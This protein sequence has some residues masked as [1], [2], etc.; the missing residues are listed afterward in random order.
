MTL[1]RMAASSPGRS[2]RRL[3]GGDLSFD[4]AV[5]H[6]WRRRCSPWT[7]RPF[8]TLYMLIC[9]LF[10]IF[11]SPV[12]AVFIEFD[13][14]L[15]PNIINST[16]RRLQFVPLFFDAK[17]N[18]SQ[19]SYNL[20]ITVFGNVTGQAREGVYPPPDDPSW[21]DPE[22]TVGKIIA[23]SPTNNKFSTLFSRYEVLSYTPY[24][25][26]GSQ[27]C[28]STVNQ[29]CPL[30]PAFD[31]NESDPSTLPGFTVAH[32]FYNSY[33]FSTL[34]STVYVRSGDMGAPDLACVSASIT[35]ALSNS[36][37]KALCITPAAI[38]AL[39]A[40][41]TVCAAI[42]SP[43]GTSNI[44]RWSSNYG[45]DEDLLRLVTPG[46]GDCL[47]YLQF[48]FLL[49]CLSLNYPGYFQPVVSKFS[50]TVLMF[51]ESFV[52]DGNGYE[53]LTDGI[54]RTDGD[55]GLTR[56][57]QLVGMAEDEDLWAGVMIWL[58][59]VIGAVVLLSQ[60]GFVVYWIYRFISKR[61]EQDL[62]SKNLPFTIGNVIRIVY[63]LFLLPL[64][65]FSMFQF[66]IAGESRTAVVAVAVIFLVGLLT[67]SGWILRN[68]FTTKPRS[69]LFDDLPT[70]LLYGPLYNTY[71]D[72]APPF[73]FNYILLTIFRGVAI[74]AV[75]QSGIAQLVLLA[76][77]EV[78]FILTLHAFRP[79]SPATSMN[80]YH[81][82]FAFARLAATL[83]SVAFV[84]SLGV[85][86]DS[87]GWIGYVILLLHGIVLV[88]GFFLNAI[89]TIVEVLARAAGAGGESRGPLVRAF[90]SRQLARRARR[91]DVRGSLNSEAAMFSQEGDVKS[92]PG[93]DGRSRSLSAS[94]AILL[95]QT[96][97]TAF[98]QNS[99]GGDYS[100]FSGSVTP[101][102]PS[103]LSSTGPAGPSSRRSTFGLKTEAIGPYYRPPRLKQPNTDATTPGTRSRG[104]GA[105]GDWYNRPYQDD[106]ENLDLADRD[107]SSLSSPERDVPSR[108]YLRTIRDDSEMNANEPNQSM[109]DYAVREVDF[110]YG[111]HRGPALSNLP[112]RRLRT[113]PADPTGPI[114]S[115]TSW[116]MSIF[117]GKSKDKGKGFEVVRSR[118]APPQMQIAEDRNASSPMNQEPY[119]DSPRQIDG[120]MARKSEDD[121]GSRNFGKQT[122]SLPILVADNNQVKDDRARSGDVY[123]LNGDEYR[124]STIR[125][126]YSRPT[127][128]V[129]SLAPIE[130]HE[131]IELTDRNGLTINNSSLTPP[132]I[133]VDPNAPQ[134]PR[135]S[136]KR[137]SADKSM[138]LSQQPPRLSMVKDSPT[139]AQDLGYDVGNPYLEVSKPP[140]NRLPFGG[141]NRSSDRL[142][143]E[144]SCESGTSSLSRGAYAISTE[145]NGIGDDA[146]PSGSHNSYDG[147]RRHPDMSPGAAAVNAGVRLAADAPERPLSTGYVTQHLA[148]D[149][150]RPSMYGQNSFLGTSAEVV[151]DQARKRSTS[152]GKLGDF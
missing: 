78:I 8:S 71:T 87:R 102:G 15:S 37:S 123:R 66:V 31:G 95:N 132:D 136:S 3:G 40:L 26:D 104:S 94:S 131:E 50:W 85:T 53:S 120:E 6:S 110:Y 121:L 143:G 151:D 72:D 149:S 105:S 35:P 27:F 29:A 119:Q 125:K 33:S 7:T 75:Q 83:L 113:G 101:R 19:P 17:F 65:S 12:P 111:T 4:N 44:Y 96:S 80:A 93:P 25:S 22:S 147:Q 57:R 18:V 90:G 97:P 130:T 47:Q 98:D 107:H 23:V 118:R 139:T 73:A 141:Q 84:P 129:P 81:T 137:V 41:A 20:N 82:I 42:F 43:W 61:Q 99:Q 92:L 70:V 32:D 68:I 109:T 48:S 148:S 91:Q 14:C 117:G 63:I 133:D 28:L 152:T 46:F 9:L 122:N 67:A 54:Y 55:Y 77:C 11:A 52:S 2:D 79:F 88:F 13:N 89:Q 100:N 36:L 108:A 34:A 115:A 74:G 69:H 142:S 124:G 128:I 49:G 114:A 116:L 127:G 140:S 135:K 38:L 150:I 21:D 86:E 16:P 5:G 56:M 58:L 144:R 64:I 10:F 126:N 146:R 62:Q 51:N 112:T 30:K 145:S 76:I 1:K 106:P 45:R 24:K 103:A 59:V 39:V 60:A 134:I 138:L